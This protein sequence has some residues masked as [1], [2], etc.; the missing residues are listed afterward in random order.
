M[1]FITAEKAY[2]LYPIATFANKQTLVTGCKPMGWN[3]M[4][5]L[6][7]HLALD[8][9][10][11]MTTLEEENMFAAGV[12]RTVEDRYSWSIPLSMDGI[13]DRSAIN[14]RSEIIPSDPSIPNVWR[15]LEFSN[16]PFMDYR[17]ATYPVFRYRYLTAHGAHTDMLRG[18]SEEQGRKANRSKQIDI[19]NYREHTKAWYVI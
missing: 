1:N 12:Y 17:I 11:G 6:Y 13:S 19:S 3:T 15:L 7:E 9:L 4:D 16:G 14:T 2:S 10:H 18:F 5:E 8:A